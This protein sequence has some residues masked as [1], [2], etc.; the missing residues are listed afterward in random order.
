[1]DRHNMMLFLKD[2]TSKLHPAGFEK[3]RRNIFDPQEDPP[4]SSNSLSMSGTS[5]SN[6][7]A[8]LI[9]SIN[10]DSKDDT[11]QTTKDNQQVC[12]REG[13][14]NKPRFDSVFCSDSCGVSALEKDLLLSIQYASKLH[15]SI[16]RG[17][18][19]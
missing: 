2:D 18:S 6:T 14:D 3:P 19:I 16:L 10:G 17:P 8:L 1:M 15:P 13:C 7:P 4:A 11:A 12:S 9:S 5:S